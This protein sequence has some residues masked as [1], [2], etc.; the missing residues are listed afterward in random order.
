M[1]QIAYIPKDPKEAATK[2]KEGLGDY[3]TFLK[4]KVIKLVLVVIPNV[5]FYGQLVLDAFQL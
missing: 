2:L 1:K 3:F 4:P 5:W